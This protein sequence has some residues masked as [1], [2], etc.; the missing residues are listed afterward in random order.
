MSVRSKDGPLALPIERGIKMTILTDEKNR[1]LQAL[2]EYILDSEE[3]D[4]LQHKEE[5]E[6][7]NDNHIYKIAE[8]AMDLLNYEARME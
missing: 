6:L 2:A 7:L 8:S 4:Y 5:N 1:L 3:D